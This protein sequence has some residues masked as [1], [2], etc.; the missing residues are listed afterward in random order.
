MKAGLLLGVAVMAGA[1]YVSLPTGAPAVT[2]VSPAGPR[3]VRGAIHVHS[4]YSDG[5]GTIDD[6]AAAAARAGLDFV[7]VTDHGN[8]TRQPDAPSY[9]SGV[10]CLDAVE[11]STDHGHIVALGVTPTPYPLGGEARDVI[12]DIAR[13]GGVSIAA[14]PD[15][16]KPALQWTDWDTGVDGFEWLNGDTAWRDERVLALARVLLT[17]PFA[18]ARALGLVLDRPESTLRRWDQIASTRRLV[19]LAGSD[20]HARLA[21]TD[22]EPRDGRLALHLPTYEDVFRVYSVTLPALR[23]TGQAVADAGALIAEV[24]AGHAYTTVDVLGAPAHLAFTATSAGQVATG[25]DEIRSGAPVAIAVSTNAP[26]GARTTLLRDG[27]PTTIV[28]GPSLRA[29]AGGE[30]AVYRVEVTLPDAPG[31]PPVPWVVSNP[32]YVR[33]PD[34]PAAV[35]T[36]VA[37]APPEAMV[38][39]FAGDSVAGWVVESSAGSKGAVDLAVLARSRAA[40]WRWAIGGARSDDPYAALVIPASAHIAASRAVLIR[41]QA[42]RPMRVSLQLRSADGQRWRRSI[43]LDDTVREVVVPF[44]AFSALASGGAAPALPSIR[45]LLLVVDTVNAQPGTNGRVMIQRI[46]YLR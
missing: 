41:A 20:A 17:Y 22:A 5:G 44:E 6:I 12:E 18:R 3:E 37:P 24:R 31:D 32:I 1:I 46:A 26:A 27:I 4:R 19:G 42:S 40:V 38:E 33:I 21:F 2:P 9:R 35:R 7:V 13:L 28:D 30:P 25:G 8:G 15:S 23:L 45:D 36:R 16:E 29:D 10:L 11:V 34:A 14:H 39:R 43:Y